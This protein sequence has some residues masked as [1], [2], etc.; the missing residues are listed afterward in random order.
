MEGVY[1]LSTLM[2]HVGSKAQS[3]N[4]PSRAG[5]SQPKS[6]VSA[7]VNWGLPSR[8]RLTSGRPTYQSLKSLTLKSPILVPS[9]KHCF[10][11]V[12]CHRWSR[13]RAPMA[14]AAPPRVPASSQATRRGAAR[15]SLL[16]ASAASLEW[17]RRREPYPAVSVAAGS[18]R[19]PS[20]A[21]TVDGSKV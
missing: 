1:I 10:A 2:A 4:E 7:R 20:G 13:R 21:L 18:A 3:S 16:A 8:S 6:Q 14:A 12:T 11:C 15:P 5:P 17:R 9:G 19:S